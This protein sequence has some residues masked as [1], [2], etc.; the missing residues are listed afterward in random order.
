MGEGFTTTMSTILSESRLASDADSD[1]KN[2]LIGV[3]GSVGDGSGD[4]L[5]LS[6]LLLLSMSSRSKICL[7]S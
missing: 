1:E 5:L 2:R 4:D 6:L 3:I 7:D